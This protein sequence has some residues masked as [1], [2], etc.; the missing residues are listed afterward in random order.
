MRPDSRISVVD[1]RSLPM[2]EVYT[3]KKRT[4]AKTLSNRIPWKTFSP[5]AFDIPVT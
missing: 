4:H 2:P 1:A 5:R 3:K